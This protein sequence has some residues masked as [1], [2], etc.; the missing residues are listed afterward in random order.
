MIANWKYSILEVD[1]G[2]YK[3]DIIDG[4]HETV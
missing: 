3:E 4:I 2:K 1:Y